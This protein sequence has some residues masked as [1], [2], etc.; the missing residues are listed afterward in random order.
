M[1][2]WFRVARL[3]EL[4]ERRPLGRM[5]GGVRLALL[6]RGDQVVAIDDRCP[7]LGF[8]LSEGFLRSGRLV[9]PLHRWAF[10]VFDEPSPAIPPEAR[11]RHHRVRI[12]SGWVEVSPIPGTAE[13]NAE[14]GS[15]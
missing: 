13:P 8:P 4:D 1:Q 2:G 7:H 11:C 10:D 3:D 14:E 5:A 6:R 12:H 9:C 15:P